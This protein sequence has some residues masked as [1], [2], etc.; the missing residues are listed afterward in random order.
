[1]RQAGAHD[2]DRLTVAG[3]RRAV[4][5]VVPGVRDADMRWPEVLEALQA[6]RGDPRGAHAAL[7]AAA[8]EDEEPFRIIPDDPGGEPAVTLTPTDLGQVTFP[9]L[10]SLAHD[11]AYLAA[12][13]AAPIHDHLLDGLA[14]YYGA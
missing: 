6:A 1:M 5:L 12:V 3:Q 8:G 2:P 14:G 13:R 4:A 11:A 9:P 7:L 10:D